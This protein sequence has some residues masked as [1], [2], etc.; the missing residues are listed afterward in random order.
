[1]LRALL[2]VRVRLQ[3]ICR[4]FPHR[5]HLHCRGDSI[6]DEQDIQDVNVSDNDKSSS[7]SAPRRSSSG[8]VALDFAPK[9][10][11]ISWVAESMDVPVPRR[12]V[13]ADW[14]FSER[15]VH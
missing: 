1:M 4:N 3:R 15:D 13:D 2:I 5:D 7:I 14:R 9:Q 6:L 8:S 11:C 10:I 12:L